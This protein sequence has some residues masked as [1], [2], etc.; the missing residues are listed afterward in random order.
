MVQYGF[1]L[2]F[3]DYMDQYYKK[4]NTITKHKWKTSPNTSVS[5]NHPPLENI[6]IDHQGSEVPASPFKLPG[7]D[8][9]I[10]KVIEQNNYTNQ[11]LKTIGKQLDKLETSLDDQSAKSTKSL[12]QPLLNL[13][14]HRS[15]RNSLV[16]T[17][18]STVKA[19]E[20][21]FT[22]LTPNDTSTSKDKGLTVLNQQPITN[23]MSDQSE[24]DTTDNELNQLA[25]QF[26]PT[27]ATTIV[28]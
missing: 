23:T 20:Q 25:Q 9:E 10:K 28:S 5:S 24:T 1:E 27:V 11:C 7:T 21:L 16:T 12:D 3:F 17:D 18:Q 14:S 6:I 15:K 8:P 2:S 19:I 4:I 26:Q 13:P 22:K